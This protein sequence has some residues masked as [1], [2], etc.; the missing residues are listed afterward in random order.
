MLEVDAV[1]RVAAREWRRLGVPRPAVRGLAEELRADLG[2]AEADS[3]DLSVITGSDVRTFARAWALEREDI[4]LRPRY[5]RF[6]GASLAGLVLGAAVAAGGLALAQFAAR[7]AVDNGAYDLFASA[8]GVAILAAYVATGAGSYVGA[9]VTARWSLSRAHDTC[10][11][12]SV[13]ALA[14]ALP[15]AAVAATA[16]AV[17]FAA[18]TGYIATKKYVA[19]ESTLVLLIIV[20]AVLTAR[21]VGARRGRCTR[22]SRSA[23]DGVEG[24][25]PA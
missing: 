5:P 16:A 22:P 21:W 4:Q 13:R 12:Q 20:V 3:V 19:V 25:L 11:R 23:N 14:L 2:A 18:S 15:A 6:L 24:M 1:L 9:L 8:N 10:T 17:G 7:V